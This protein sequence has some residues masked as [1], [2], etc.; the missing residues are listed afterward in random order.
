MLQNDCLKCPKSV[1][2]SRREEARRR[3]GAEEG[4]TADRVTEE[5]ETDP[6]C[7]QD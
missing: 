6:V 5:A 2:V 1:K 3:G 7:S 4:G